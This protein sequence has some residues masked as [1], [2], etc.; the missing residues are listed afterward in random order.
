MNENERFRRN[1][2]L[3]RAYPSPRKLAIKTKSSVAA[4]TSYLREPTR[5]GLWKMQ[6]E[7]KPENGITELIKTLALE[8]YEKEAKGKRKE[9][10][11]LLFRRTSD[12]LSDIDN[13]TFILRLFLQIYKE[14]PGMETEDISYQ[15]PEFGYFRGFLKI[16]NNKISKEYADALDF[17]GKKIYFGG[18]NGYAGSRISGIKTG[19]YVLM[20]NGT[21][22][23]NNG[24]TFE[25]LGV[26]EQPLRDIYEFLNLLGKAED[27]QIY[28][29]FSPE[30]ELLSPYVEVTSSMLDSLKISTGYSRHF[31]K[32]AAD[33]DGD[34][35]TGCVA[36]AAIMAEECLTQILETLSRKPCPPRQT[37]GN[38]SKGINNLC[39]EISS[40]NDKVQTLRTPPEVIKKIKANEARDEQ[41]LIAYATSQILS[42]V[43]QQIGSK[44]MDDSPEKSQEFRIFPTTVKI[45]LENLISYRNY[46]L[47]KS[48]VN[49]GSLEALKSVHGALAL[50]LWWNEQKQSV[51]ASLSHVEVLELLVESSKK[52]DK[53]TYSTA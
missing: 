30:D 7:W 45:G 22:G 46:S 10:K 3:R 38:L 16:D 50:L 18:F 43:D 42:Y 47:H 49:I 41:G 4:A 23:S 31:E 2:A 24:F 12:A 21:T 27:M 9:T 14:A 17:F 1:R 37:L 5:N 25:I 33:F 32:M 52:L 28:T 8:R 48:T 44:L 36:T 20:E 34:N 26:S 53:Q 6:F 11:E 19:N 39:R 40:P 35:F 13:I 51:K 29:I 15:Y